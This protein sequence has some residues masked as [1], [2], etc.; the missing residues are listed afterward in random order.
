[1]VSP[2]LLPR[3]IHGQWRGIFAR[4]RARRVLV[5]SSLFSAL[6]GTLLGA[7]IVFFNASSWLFLSS[8]ALIIAPFFSIMVIHDVTRNIAYDTG[9]RVDE[10]EQAIRHE[11]Y[12][13]SYYLLRNATMVLLALVMA[14]LIW[15]NP[16]MLQTAFAH[17][18]RHGNLAILGLG[19]AY[20]VSGLPS[21]MIA[22]HKPNAPVDEM[23]LAPGLRSV[24]LLVL[25]PIIIGVSLCGLLV[26]LIGL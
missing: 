16:E 1:M 25:P 5:I 8:W 11:A 12:R 20:L 15:G 14:V 7:Y 21:W 17:L 4:Q 3:T 23:I 24:L 18:V 6:V 22:W 2:K 9:R 19:C 26:E 13:S 10:R